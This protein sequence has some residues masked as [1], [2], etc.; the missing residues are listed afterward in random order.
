MKETLE[1]FVDVT[2]GFKGP[3]ASGDSL[4]NVVFD[5]VKYFVSQGF[6]AVTSGH[7]TDLRVSIRVP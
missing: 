3:R 1:D 2:G 6:Q 7:E 5:I 4:T